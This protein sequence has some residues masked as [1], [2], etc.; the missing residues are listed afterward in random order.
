M[1][2]RLSADLIGFFWEMVGR[3]VQGD[4][5]AILASRAHVSIDVPSNTL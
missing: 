5:D 1:L 4:I 3:I 2:A